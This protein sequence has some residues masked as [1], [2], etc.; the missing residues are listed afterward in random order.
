MRFYR[1]F[2]KFFS[3]IKLAVFI[4][5]SLAVVSGVGTIYESRFDAEVAKQLVYHSP[6]MYGV[7][8]LLCLS[9]L[10]VMVDRWPWRAHHSG[11][12]LAHIGILVLLFGSWISAKYGI[13]GSISFEIG[14]SRDQ[15]TVNDR[16]LIVYSS[17]EGDRFQKLFETPVNFLKD[18]PS[19]NKPFRVALG[20][21]EVT[22]KE[23]VHFAFRES[24]IKV[25]EDPLDG[26]AVRFQLVN[27]RVNL[28]EWLRLKRSETDVNVDLGPAQV[29]LVREWA[30][31]NTKNEIQLR[32]QVG[33]KLDFKIFGEGAKVRKSGQLV[34]GQTLATG[35]MGL[36]FRVLRYFDQAQEVITYKPSPTASPMSVS[37]IRFGFR[38]RDQWLGLNSVLRLY[39]EDRV[40][41]ISYG[42]RRLQLAFPLTLKAFRMGTYQGTTRASSYESEVDVPGLDTTLI[43]MNEPLQYEGFTFYQSSFEK[44][45]KGEPVVSVLSVNHDPGR[46]IKYLGSALIV[47]G[48]ILLFYF[49]RAKLWPSRRTQ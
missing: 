38:G 37:A 7:L 23:Y 21:D 2:I 14:Q 36:E 32:P 30:R 27:S 35:W 44:N 47:L 34:E 24:E 45:E 9:L 11:F 16:D 8:G 48:A 42:N 26:P 13:D 40:Y 1:R 39:L 6:Y 18:P 12:V 49:K 22:V 28:T 17:F 31:P 15:V 4:I 25:S 29:R 20:Q 33:G 3:S 10:A 5:L 41:V 46:W 43:S 19:E